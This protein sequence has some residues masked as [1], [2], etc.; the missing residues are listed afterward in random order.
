VAGCRH[1]HGSAPNLEVNEKGI[2]LHVPVIDKS[3]RDDGT[4]SR[5]AFIYDKGQDINM[6]P[7][8]K[9][10][11]GTLVNGGAALL[12]RASN[13]CHCSN[14]Q[15]AHTQRDRK[16]VEILFSHLKRI[17]RLGGLRPRRPIQ[18]AVFRD[19]VNYPRVVEKRPNVGII[20]T[21]CYSRAVD[22][23]TSRA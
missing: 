18:S 9:R 6:C 7:A 16:K 23:G 1:R 4:F 8:R 19:A 15:F 14:Q 12:Y 10:S 13:P 5:K 21:P 3:K 17:P 2:A 11:S 20:R 22:L